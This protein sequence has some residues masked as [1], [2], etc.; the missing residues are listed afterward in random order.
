MIYDI[1][2]P[3]HPDMAVYKNRDEKKPRFK[4]VKTFENDGVYETDIT[5]NLH[6]GTHIDFPLH[7]LES[8]KNS[9]KH[10][11]KTLLGDAKVLD[12]TT[13][14][15]GITDNDLAGFDIKDNDF[16][17]LKTRNSYHDEFDFEFVY[18]SKTGA[19]YLVDKGVRGVGIDALGIERN[20]P[21][22]PTHDLLL[23]EEILILEGIRL[24]DV[25]EGTYEMIALPLSIEDVEALPVRAILKTK[26]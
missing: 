23:N 12:L 21:G 11:I 26:D 16:I 9:H 3:I 6:T 10:N 22:H 5:M 2:M 15:E 14:R 25:S 18:L 13:V 24:K 1:S 8:G 7:T 19:E 4:T 20:Q 17:L